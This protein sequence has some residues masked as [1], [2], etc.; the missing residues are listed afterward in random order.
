MKA[1]G[2]WWPLCAE[3]GRVVLAL[4]R[5][6]RSFR[7]LGPKELLEK[8]RAQG[9]LARERSPAERH[10]L[11]QVIGWIDSRLPGGT[12]YRRALLEISLDRGAAQTSLCL[13][14][15]LDGDRVSGHAWVADPVEDN[16]G[17]QA[18]IRM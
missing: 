14:F 15:N 17:Y 11:R 12:C 5:L 6:E 1:I 2:E 13:G 8:A 7:R 3:A 4:A 9:V 10:R 16:A 18:C